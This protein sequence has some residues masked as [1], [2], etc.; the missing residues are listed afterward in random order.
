MLKLKSATHAIQQ[1]ITITQLASVLYVKKDLFIIKHLINV[2]LTTIIKLALLKLLIIMHTKT[3]VNHALLDKSLIN[4][5]RNAFMQI[6]LV[7]ALLI[8]HYTIIKSISVSH[9][10]REPNITNIS[11]NA[12]P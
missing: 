3:N 4:N 10:H 8:N 11:L 7:Y 6:I 9:A 2:R 5:Y 12:I 1:N